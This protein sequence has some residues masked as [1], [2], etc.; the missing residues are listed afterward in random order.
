MT[1][2]EILF[3][4]LDAEN[5]LAVAGGE[6]SWGLVSQMVFGNQ[7]VQTSSYKINKSWGCSVQPGDYHI[8]LQM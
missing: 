5:R 7:E 3:I 4:C 6:G 8:I 2:K 1:F